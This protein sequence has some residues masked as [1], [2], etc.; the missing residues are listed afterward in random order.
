MKGF[1]ICP[2][3]KGNG[4]TRHVFE[5]EKVEL[6]CKAC[7][8]QG[9]VSDDKFFSQTYDTKNW[10]N[11]PSTCYYQG[12]CLDYTLFPNLKIVIDIK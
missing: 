8:S 12:P 5:A 7:L 6:P 11:E 3:C 10:L 1:K 4:F 9:E 2:N